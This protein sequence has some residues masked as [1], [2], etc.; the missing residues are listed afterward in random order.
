MLEEL[1]KVV[2]TAVLNKLTNDIQA[3]NRPA[4]VKDV[5][6]AAILRE[7]DAKQEVPIQDKAEEDPGAI[8]QVADQENREA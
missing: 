2:S 1:A 8:Q 7:E 5:N 6:L 3:T 4:I